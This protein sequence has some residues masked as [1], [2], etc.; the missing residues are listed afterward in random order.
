M[1]LSAVPAG[2]VPVGSYD[3]STTSAAST[4]ILA[5]AQVDPGDAFYAIASV[6][7]NPAY[8][9][10]PVAY[11]RKNLKVNPNRG[12]D[13]QYHQNN[14]DQWQK[15]GTGG[16]LLLTGLDDWD[17]GDS[18]PNG[19]GIYERGFTSQ[20]GGAITIMFAD[21]VYSDNSGSL[22]L[23][24][25]KKA[26][27]DFT[28][29][30]VD[31]FTSGASKIRVSVQPAESYGRVFLV[32]EDP[33]VVQFDGGQSWI[34][35]SSPVQDVSLYGSAVESGS[36]ADA[37]G[38]TLV[39]AVWDYVPAAAP[40]SFGAFALAAG[41]DTD[42]S[43]PAKGASEGQGQTNVLGEVSVTSHDEKKATKTLLDKAWE[44][45]MSE[46][47]DTPNDIG[48]L[49]A[50]KAASV[51][52][53]AIDNRIFEVENDPNLTPFEKDLRLQRFDT[54]ETDVLPSWQGAV[55][56]G[57]ASDIFDIVDLLRFGNTDS[58]FDGTVRG[59]LAPVNGELEGFDAEDFNWEIKPDRF[60]FQFRPQSLGSVL[61]GI[62]AG[63]NDPVN[64][65]I[66]HPGSFVKEISV[67][68]ELF[69]INGDD[70]ISITAGLIDAPEGASWANGKYGAFI[71]FDP[72]IIPHFPD[73]LHGRMRLGGFYQPES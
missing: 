54:F 69:G 21:T 2:Y 23:D 61:D 5:D 68:Y 43:T 37:A 18:T 73:D 39:R 30:S 52:M 56:S 44:K 19:D 4:V 57:A 32:S 10:R 46:V 70:K 62:Q 41:P 33:T 53:G 64:N 45:V 29:S 24:L 31:I 59:L 48:K 12:V 42:S 40:L 51:L 60:S 27:V 25:F 15:A 35:L 1:F 16:H 28:S 8:G 20:D 66:T 72:Q 49:A 55:A 50:K 63:D 71:D 6:N 11:I 47:N 13:A 34:Q 3:I 26:T 17:P 58:D 14:A 22:H 36:F 67:R 7:N 38:M 9:N 65:L